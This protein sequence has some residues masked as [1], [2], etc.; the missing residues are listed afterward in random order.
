MIQHRDG[1]QLRAGGKVGESLRWVNRQKPT[2]AI[3]L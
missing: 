2:E 3:Y 1:L